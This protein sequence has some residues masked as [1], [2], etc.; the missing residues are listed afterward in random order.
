MKLNLSGTVG[1]GA[2]KVGGIAT[3]CGINTL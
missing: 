1:V 3:N 2:M